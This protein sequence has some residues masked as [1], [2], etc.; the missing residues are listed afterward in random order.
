M[1]SSQSFEQVAG[2]SVKAEQLE[3]EIKDLE[4][5]REQTRKTLEASIQRAFD[6]KE[7]KKVDKQLQDATKRS[8]ELSKAVPSDKV[9]K[10]QG[11]VKA[12]IQ[13]LQKKR[14]ELQDRF[15]SPLPII[16]RLIKQEEQQLLKIQAGEIKDLPSD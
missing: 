10:E 3:K 2:S 4:S 13:E 11:E 16:E 15:G 8:V 5:Q 9:R 12:K 14:Q 7:I 1:D 6:F